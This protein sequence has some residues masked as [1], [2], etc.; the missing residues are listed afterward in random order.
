M[1]TE[2][3]KSVK[4]TSNS[5][6]IFSN[7]QAHMRTH[8]M[9]TGAGQEF[10]L[11]FKASNMEDVLASFAV[12]GGVAYTKPASF[13]QPDKKS[14][15]E[16]K[17]STFESLASFRGAKV[18]FQYGPKDVKGTLLSTDFIQESNNN[19]EYVTKRFISLISDNGIETY[20]W[21]E[22]QRIEFEEPEI[23]AE[24][25]K[26]LS[27]NRQKLK[28]DAVFLNVGLK[29]KEGKDQAEAM[30]QWV[31]QL[32]PWSLSYRFNK[33]E[34]GYRLDVFGIVHN[35]TDV[36]WN[37]T[38]F[39]LVTGKPLTFI[40]NLD[41]QQTVKRNQVNVQETVARGGH[42]AEDGIPLSYLNDASES[43]LESVQ[44][45]K[46]FAT[47]KTAAS[48][49]SRSMGAA[50]PA[51]GNIANFQ[52]SQYVNQKAAPI[53]TVTTEE[54]GDFCMYKQDTPLSIPANTTATMPLFSRELK[55][56]KTVLVYD[57]N[58]NTTRPFRA[59]QFTN[60]TG[61]TLGL[62][63]AVVFEKNLFQGKCIL[64]HSKPSEKRMLY[65][66]E[67]TG[68]S[69]KMV[70]SRN[71][72][73]RER[74]LIAQGTAT[75]RSWQSMTTTYT[76]RN[77]KKEDFT[78]LLDYQKSLAQ[79]SECTCTINQEK[80]KA[81]EELPN[82]LRYSITLP[83]NATV[84]VTVNER[85][86]N[87]QSF[88]ITNVDWFLTTYVVGEKAIIN[89]K[90]IQKVLSVKKAV[91]G[92]NYEINA[93]NLSIAKANEIKNNMTEVLKLGDKVG[94]LV[95]YQDKL[96]NAIQTIEEKGIELEKLEA[97]ANKL[98]QEMFDSVG[99]LSGDWSFN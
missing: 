97:E 9:V 47:A 54:I 52:N 61:E 92:K 27:A 99:N 35:G 51:G 2:E 17:G 95:A 80:V 34:T 50:P 39:T 1:I 16:L 13:T 20:T 26:A 84:T 86:L 83:A 78:V 11:P 10:A 3:V 71:N 56:A 62:G 23:V 76:L 68:V 55:D 14:S 53:A 63:V 8:R 98:Q 18:K 30:F 22:I 6:T 19:G 79:T 49:S 94:N 21:S 96:K 73:N 7:G 42:K 75:S 5:V 15:L 28:P 67:E 36:D 41:K 81:S 44:S 46:P 66:A 70:S 90:G 38:I 4:T 91:D 89:D 48:Y 65:Y 29:P 93:C 12:F 32:N 45:N 74:L 59:I 57:Q 58:Q 25:V 43:T 82:G 40:S 64:N 87:S 31:E 33:I 88:E 85:F 72:D 24:I 69:V 37:D 77:V 60:D